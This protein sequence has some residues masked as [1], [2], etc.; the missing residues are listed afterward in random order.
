MVKWILS[1]MTILSFVAVHASAQT[2]PSK[3][4]LT[5]SP[6]DV[7]DLIMKQSYLAEEINLR[8]Q[9]SRFAMEEIESRYQFGLLFE[10]GYEDSKFESA[11]NSFLLRN[12]SYTTLFSLNKS[13]STGTLTQL[14]YTRSSLKP[15]YS[16][17][18]TTPA[19]NSTV[20]T[21]GLVLTQNLLNNFFG[22]AD[23]AD[24]RSARQT[25]RAAQINR[26][27]ELQNLVLDGIRAYWSTYV[28]QETFQE[29]LNS[30]NRYQK[31]VDQIKKK[32]GYGYS[33]PGELAQAQAELEARDQN[34]VRSSAN[35]LAALDS[36]KTLLK[37]SPETEIKF[38]VSEEIPTPPVSTPVEIKNLRL[39]KATQLQLMAAE[40]ALKAASSRNWP[41]LNFVGKVYQQG[42]DE[43]AN[44]AY[45]EMSSGTHPQYYMGVQ[46]KYNFGTSYNDE[47]EL[48]R[49][50]ARNLAQSQFDRTQL[51][52]R[53]YENNLIRHLQSF[54][55]IANSTKAQL[56]F[57]EKA[58]QDLS[59]SYSQGR[60]DI[61]ILIN[62]L[63]SYFDAE[64]QFIRAL[65]DY[66]TAL[67]EWAAFRDDLIKVTV[68]PE[69]GEK[70]DN[71]SEES[72]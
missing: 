37:I 25:Y 64:V 1:W 35:Y 49:R 42:L 45:S 38:S 48:N 58:A 71:L 69:T 20:D 16:L 54:F 52:L 41:E 63:N 53:D 7:A 11:Q 40:N 36:L 55:T 27:T 18:A 8:S 5:L 23:R 34:V 72:L 26:V 31:L 57:R 19:R 65:G 10:T 68:D 39:S 21:V 22:V 12:E 66:Q 3:A 30:R 2:A 43:N 28:S 51:E 24:L 29:A 62:A 17:G 56:G 14:T 6:K 59:R 50:A 67:N 15:E 9:T 47:R 60:T 32:T 70:M 61:S 33:G 4:S 44:E 13:F 46:V